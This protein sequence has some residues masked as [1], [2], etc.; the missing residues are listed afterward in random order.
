MQ[1]KDQ[2]SNSSNGDGKPAI[3][4]AIVVR[5]ARQHNLKNISLKIP[6][7]KM[8][9]V[10]G[11]SGSG[12][13]S[14]AFDTIFAEGQRRYVESLSAYARQFL[15]QL[16]KPDVDGIDGLS[17]AISIDQKSTSHNPRSTVG[18]V[19][20][21][22][23]Y[24]RLLYA[25]VG[26]PHC[27]QCKRLIN[28]QT[29]DQIVDQVLNLP[30]GTKIQILAPLIAGRKGEYQALFQDLRKEG[31]VRIRLD[32]EVVEL[33]DDIALDKNKKHT[34]ELVIDRLI[35]KP[36]IQSRLADSLQLG[37]KWGKSNVLV[38]VLDQSNPRTL[39]FSENFACANCN[40]SFAEISP[41]IF[42][43]NSPYGACSDCHGLGATF[44]VD[45]TLVVPD[46][47]K[48]IAE[49]AI[50]PWAKTGNVYYDQILSSV[51]KHYKFSIETPFHKLTRPQQAVIL[52]GSGDE[53][54]KLAHDSFDG[55]EFCEYKKPFEGVIPNLKRRHDESQSDRVKQE[56]ENFMTQMPCESCKGARL[57][58]ESLAISIDELSIAEVSHLSVEKASR[59]F[60]DLPAKFTE[61]QKTISHQILLE[62]RARLKFLLDVGLE[63]LTLDRQA[64]TLSGGEAQRIRLATQIGSGLSGVLYVLDEPSVG[65]HQRDN[66]RLIATLK[67]LR[68]LGNTLLV[69]E[70]DEDT[71]RQADWIVDI[72][73]GAGLHG[74]YVVAEGDINA[75]CNAKDS[76]TGAYL[77]GRKVIPVPKKR[78]S[79]NGLTIKIVDASLNN[80]KNIS[81]ELDLNQFIAVTGVSGSGKSTL[82]NDLLY[83][84]L[85]HR[86][87]GSVPHPKGLKRVE[88]VEELDKVIDIDQSPIGRTPRSNPATY[89]GL[90]DIIREVYSMTNEAKARGYLPGRFSF[91]VKGG[92]CE[93]CRGE[94]MN[95]I[96][97]NF[98][99]SVF[100]NCEVCKGA[101]Y[102]RETLEVRFKGKSI[103][104]VLE[105][106]VE[107]ALSFF[108]NVPKAVSKL[109]TLLEVGLDYIKLGQPATTLSGGE[110]Q[111]VK[112][113]EQ[114]SKRATG[115]TIYIL[116][117]PTTG[118]S[119]QDVDKLL[120]VLNKLV[121]SGNT[122]LIIE[123][124]LDVIKQADW[125]VDLGPEG[126][127]RGGTVVC[128]GTPEDVARNEQ[129][130][131]G[132]FLREALN[133]K[134]LV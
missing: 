107:E 78:R 76:A 96:E 30:D 104:D 110:A 31:F 46:S 80:L 102:N 41:R 130:Y 94:G 128:V 75:I 44:E 114:L 119:F 73:P 28:P 97:M 53:K 81:V 74:G 132:K 133:M 8:V 91:N 16:D 126:G 11:V 38:D 20:E 123:H 23:D 45:P 63:Y 35:V 120:T 25:R 29:I 49:G 71:I 131:T 4:D 77:S 52:Y 92:R 115:R 58:P 117:E 34:I 60:A 55:R 36:T 85:R 112:L 127:D 113:A 10:T 27:P 19:T 48:S 54:I 111:R 125:I 7:H 22:Y 59:F 1:P 40:I 70:H 18:T 14:L 33:E 88:G 43:F 68:D 42:S 105:M 106:T 39:L 62:V 84:Y 57:K 98:L 6:R 89:T 15:G 121:D 86:L 95:E 2:M 101:R 66:N 134:L 64:N 51:A 122:V 61:R 67:R 5:G 116:D 93:A 3:N 47:S 12:K 87:N 21:I 99:P 103:A 17:P 24:L 124:N 9:V 83:Q 32:S 100:V 79:G 37:L 118:L 13:S 56:I 26:T 72:G 82:V 65:L 50:F 90:F 109:E 69:V 129:S 108:A